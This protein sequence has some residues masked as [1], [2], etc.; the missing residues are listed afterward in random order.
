M[1]PIVRNTLI[2]LAVMLLIAAGVIAWAASRLDDVVRDYT[3][4]ALEQKLQS[5]VELGEVK[6]SLVTGVSATL[7]HLVIRHHGRT[8]VPPFI[9]IGEAHVRTSY[10]SMFA[11]PKRIGL[12]ELKALTIHIP[13]KREGEPR[14]SRGPKSGKP[15][16]DFVINRVIADGTMLRIL[17]KD[18]A[19]EPLEWDIRKLAL[20]S[21]GPREAMRFDAVLTNAKPPGDIESKGSFGPWNATELGL[22]PVSGDYSFRNAD[23]SVFKGIAGI[24]S[25]TGRY[26][27][28]LG[29]LETSGTTDTPDFRLGEGG[30]RVPLKTNFHAIVDGTSGDTFLEPVNAVLG[31]TP[32]VCKGAVAGTPGVKGKTISL[33]TSISGGRIDDLLRLAVK[34][35]KP[36]LAG[37][38]DLNAKLVIP[39]G[40]VDV[41]RKLQL[42]G[43]FAMKQVRFTSPE[44]QEKIASMSKRAQGQPGAPTEDVASEFQGKFDVRNGTIT[45]DRLAFALPGAQVLLSGS[46]GMRSEN[47]DMAGRLRMQARISQAVGGMK[48]WLLKPIDPFFAKEGAGA[49]IPIK[50]TG[51]RE[52][53]E[54]GLNFRGKKHKKK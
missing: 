41:V 36:P 8:D 4:R 2:T 10:L 7:K 16:P 34:G 25:S 38:M 12:V 27:G 11:S 42:T 39:P 15:V 18:P 30:N 23:L 48:R 54:F 19:R 6:L 49:V 17:P 32:I 52:K 46:Y 22:T 51:S 43:A 33:Q 45:M 50:I 29:R 20:K 31:K 9:E 53:P 35:N 28:V 1:R 37:G 21:A 26:S 3:Q 40:Q 13:P 14:F 24:L 44:L 47:I 5:D